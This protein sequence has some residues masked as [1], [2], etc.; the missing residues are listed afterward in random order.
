[1]INNSCPLPKALAN[2]G[3]SVR[4]PALAVHAA[5]TTA[6]PLRHAVHPLPGRAVAEV[7]LAHGGGRPGVPE[8][9]GVINT[10]PVA[11]QLGKKHVLQQ[12]GL[13]DHGLG[14]GVVGL[15]G[16]MHSLLV[17]VVGV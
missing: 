7:S 9:V 14:H 6:Q 17:R 8:W 11:T 13:E 1:M 10:R 4:M 12:A 16:A 3:G 2:E 15:R 5:V